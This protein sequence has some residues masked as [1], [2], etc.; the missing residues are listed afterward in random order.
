MYI[1][2]EENMEP[3]LKNYKW[4]S[5]F[6]SKISLS[7]T[8]MYIYSGV[9]ET[10]KYCSSF[11]ERK[12]TWRISKWV[13]VYPSYPRRTSLVNVSETEAKMVQV[14]DIIGYGDQ[15]LK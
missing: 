1:L 11:I 7:R 5:F 4:Y 15:G 8:K 10:S 6:I 13:L 2:K 14:D 12:K 9:I 3:S